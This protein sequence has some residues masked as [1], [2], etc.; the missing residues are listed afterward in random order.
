MSEFVEQC[1]REW[2]RLGVAD[3]LAEEMAADLA[4]DLDEAEAE[5]VSAAEYLGTSASDPRS[6]AASWASERGIVP[7][8]PS[9]E[10]GRRRPLALV[11]FTAWQR[12]RWSSPRCC[13][14]PGSPRWHSDVE[15][16]AA[17]PSPASGEPPSIRRRPSSSGSRGRP[18]RVDPPVRRDRR[19]RLLCVAV[20]ALGPL[21]T[22]DRLASQSFFL[23]IGRRSLQGAISWQSGVVLGRRGPATD[24]SPGSHERPSRAPA[25]AC[26]GRPTTSPT[27]PTSPTSSTTV[28]SAYQAGLA[29]AQCMRAHGLSDFPN[30]SPGSSVIGQ[31]GPCP[32]RPQHVRTTPANT[33]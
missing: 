32:T 1:R 30:P 29:Y 12:S 14:R 31:P 21:A 3:P 2:R 17:S 8:P 24:D 15:N 22:T 4:S 33:S 5:G 6:F 10:K 11:A 28:S 19:A 9:P 27:S 16:S 26:G 7:A 18:G 20:A 13:S 23:V 25:A